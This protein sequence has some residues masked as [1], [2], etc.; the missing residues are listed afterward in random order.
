MILWAPLKEQEESVSQ[1]SLQVKRAELSRC[2]ES[3]CNDCFR[4]GKSLQK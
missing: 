3:Q 4:S 1:L 2:E